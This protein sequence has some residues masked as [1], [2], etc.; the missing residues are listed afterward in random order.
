MLSASTKNPLIV[1]GPTG[2]SKGLS[3]NIALSIR[4]AF[5]GK[6]FTEVVINVQKD[7]QLL[8]LKLYLKHK[9]GNNKI[10]KKL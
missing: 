7:Q 10:L 2:T 1:S 5:K 9:L 6:Q 8:K 4:E 3:H